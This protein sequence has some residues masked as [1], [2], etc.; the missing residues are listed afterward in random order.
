[1]VAWLGGEKGIRSQQ[2]A[3][4][5]EQGGIFMK[6]AA[7]LAGLGCIG[8]NNMLVTREFGPRVRLR[9]VFIEEV[10][11]PTGPVDFD[12][13]ADCALPCRKACPRRAFEKRI[14]VRNEFK[15][16][17]LPARNGVYN[18]SLCNAEMKANQENYEEVEI[19]DKTEPGR[20]VRFCRR[21]EFS[22]PVGKTG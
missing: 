21:C 18:R 15:V 1:M 5:I 10:L 2:I 12:P 20:L 17:R 9:A 7:V 3:Y 22:C 19:K 14:C 4:H 16:D 6:D 13:C 11:P 8:K